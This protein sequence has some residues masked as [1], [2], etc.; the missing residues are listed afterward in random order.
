MSK[1]SIEYFYILI[2]ICHPINSETIT[3]QPVSNV[4]LSQISLYTSQIINRTAIMIIAPI[5]LNNNI[6]TTQQ[7]HTNISTKTNSYI[8]LIILLLLFFLYN[9][10]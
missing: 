5:L 2:L 8:I 9:Y 7:P 10:I 3:N 6:T 1:V 4:T